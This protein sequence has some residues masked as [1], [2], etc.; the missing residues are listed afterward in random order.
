MGD[1]FERYWQVVFAY[2]RRRGC[3]DDTA[4]EIVQDVMLAVFEK[5]DIYRYDPGRGRFRDW[6]GES[7]G[8]RWPGTGGVP[9]SGSAHVAAI[10]GAAFPSP[11][12]QSLRPTQRGKTPS[13]KRCSWPFWT[14]FEQG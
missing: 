4:E 13:S 1:F 2:A 3:S 6:L 14:S 5:R 9:P 11:I 10:R 8:T 12:R 7:C